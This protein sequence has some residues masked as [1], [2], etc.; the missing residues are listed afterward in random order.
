MITVCMTQSRKYSVSLSLRW[1]SVPWRPWNLRSEL[2]TLRRNDTSRSA[3]GF[4]ASCT[5]TCTVN[6]QSVTM[7]KR[8]HFIGRT[9]RWAPAA[10]PRSTVSLDG[11][12]HSSPR[13]RRASTANSAK[14]RWQSASSATLTATV[15]S[16]PVVNLTHFHHIITYAE[17]TTMRCQP[18]ST[19]EKNRNGK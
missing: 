5:A 11:H 12:Q 13:S 17:H 8:Q 15:V 19:A 3:Y 18:K 7:A 6:S 9:D 10:E 14:S 1:S 16:R 2:F 4:S